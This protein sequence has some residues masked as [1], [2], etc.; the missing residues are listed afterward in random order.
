MKRFVGWVLAGTGAIGTC[1]GAYHM[2]SGSATAPLHPLP[3]NAMT[4][5]LIGLALLT[6]GLVWARD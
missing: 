4:G 3:V 6:I 1:W 5:G 2:L